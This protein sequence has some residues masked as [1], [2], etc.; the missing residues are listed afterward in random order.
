[1]SYIKIDKLKLINLKYSLSKEILRTNRAGSFKNSTIINCN[2]RKYHGLLICP[3]SKFNN[4]NY[5]L[6]SS[7]DETIIQHDAE[8]HLGIHRYPGEYFPRGHKYISEYETDP[9]PS[10]IY[11]V[12]GV[13]LKKEMLLV[14]N[15]ERILIRYTLLDAHSSTKLRLQPFLAFRN[16]HSLTKANLDANTKYHDCKNGIKIKMYNG[17]PY[18][19]LQISKK[20]NFI[21]APNWFYNIEYLE[22]KK[23]GYEY[24]EDLFVPGYF[25]ASIKKGESIIVSAGTKEAVTSSLKRQFTSEIG[26]K[27]PRNSFENCLENSAQQFISRH[28]KNTKIIAGF[29]WFGH[30]ARNTFISLP[31]LT[32]TLGDKKTFI[33]VIDT[34]IS[35]MKN[36]FFPNEGSVEEPGGDSA[37]ASLWLFWALQKYHD[38]D[39]DFNIWQKYG[40]KLTNILEC[41][42]KG[43]DFN[44]KMHDN[45][46]LWAGVEGN[47][48]S[49]MDAYA[50]NKPVTPRIGFTVEINALW[51]NAI[52][53][54][55]ELAKDENDT[56][57]IKNWKYLPALIKKSFVE[58]F[59]DK[60][61]EYLIDY[62]DY[63]H[64]NKEVRPNQLFALSLPYSPLNK[65]KRKHVMD[66]IVNELLTPRGL[67]TLSPKSPYY[68]GVYG[69]NHTE[70]SLAYHQ[71]TVRL[72]LMGHFTEAYLN[73]Y[74]K[75]GIH[76]IEKLYK[77]FEEC[78]TEYGIGTLPEVYDG[79]PPHKPNGATSFAPSVGEILR[80]NYIINKLKN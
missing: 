56:K 12:G 13:L 77:N 10:I 26:N 73:I 64:K 14:E 46:L 49:W 16:I 36:C 43:T 76:F 55:L 37:D 72:W 60:K 53:F 50:N 24:S 29:P 11:R 51:Y 67:R 21:A 61:N 58:N 74:N 79:N 75:S 18:L 66:V 80:V 59:W 6:L 48:V 68:K 31:G 78:I 57:F 71:G 45:N 65:E 2:T 4:E 5:I 19:H 52:N 30:W 25:E 40:K 63:K 20:S 54:A 3:I 39:K 8:F 7:L 35:E 27:T 62:F 28:N 17:F 70:R 41:Y 32:L 22:E 1:M 34:M 23:R 44:I 33:D 38:E 9:I 42:K 69:G 15:E 47:A